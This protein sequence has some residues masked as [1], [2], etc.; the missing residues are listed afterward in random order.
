MSARRERR[1]NAIV[2]GLLFVTL[3]GFGA[4]AID[5]GLVRVGSAHLQHS[6]DSAAFSGVQQLDG[7]ADGV[8]RAIATAIEIAA[9]NPVLH[10]AVALADTDIVPGNWDPASQQFT[11]WDG[12]DP[13]VVNALR[14]Q[15]DE[16][17]VPAG[18]GAVAFARSTY[19]VEARA[20]AFR[21]WAAGPL[22]ETPCYLPL[23]IPDCTVSGLPE[24]VNP[25]PMRFTFNPS[26]SDNVAWGLPGVNPNTADV[27]DHLAGQCSG[28][29][30]GIGDPLHVNEGLHNDALREVAQILNGEHGTDASLW[31]LAAYGALPLRDGQHANTLVESG[32]VPSRWGYTLEGPVPLVAGGEDCSVP[33]TGT[34][35]ITG[36]A[37]GIIYDVDLHGADKN[38]FIQ[39]DRTGTHETWGQTTTDPEP[40]ADNVLGAGPPR[41]GGW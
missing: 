1:G 23:A 8:D 3:L 7:T 6:L 25:P 17:P 26:P 28:R 5:V 2:V 37:W 14:I 36:F 34:M 41:F 21:P 19:A 10:T 40:P 27:R 15:T 24:G 39:L 31:D 11:A 9:E 30:V 22:S 16:L 38:L 35:E 18:L 29:P 13:A 33:F 4:L 32:V 12:V 20:M